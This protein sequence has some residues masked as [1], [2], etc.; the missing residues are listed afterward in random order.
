MSNLTL[1]SG[2]A[3][4]GTKDVALIQHK[5]GLLFSCTHRLI[6]C[7]LKSFVYCFKSRVVH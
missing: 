4:N 6:V 7:G 2:T 5:T 3:Q 1:N